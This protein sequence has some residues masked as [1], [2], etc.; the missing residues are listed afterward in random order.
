MMMFVKKLFFPPK[1]SPSFSFISQGTKLTG[2]IELTGDVL[3]GGDI[4]GQLLSEA[5]I[6]IEQG[7]TIQGEVKCH[8][9]IVDGHF[10][11]RL[12]CERLVIQRNGVVDG[13]VASTSMQIL[14][15]G[16]FIGMRIKE[17][18]PTIYSHAIG[19]TPA[20]DNRNLSHVQ[21]DVIESR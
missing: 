20:T 12:I 9:F 17:D 16:Q 5:N 1:K 14:E 15:G 7:G 3:V 10:K 11:G 18:A 19:H 13:E 8:E 6:T 2:N 21:N 4:Q